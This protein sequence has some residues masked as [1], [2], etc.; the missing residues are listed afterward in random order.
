M[1]WLKFVRACLWQPAKY[2]AYIKVD[3]LY[4]KSKT[5]FLF[6]FSR[7]VAAQ[8]LSRAVVDYFLQLTGCI[9]FYVTAFIS[10]LT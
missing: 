2:Q 7:P 6:P 1:S 10:K 3:S 8:E 9:S 5:R 4:Q